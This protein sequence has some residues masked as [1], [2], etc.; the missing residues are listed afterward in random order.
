MSLSAPESRIGLPRTQT[1]WLAVIRSVEPSPAVRDLR[2]GGLRRL[3]M[4]HWHDTMVDR[5]EPNGP[6]YLTGWTISGL[7][8]IATIVAVWILGI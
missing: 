3:F 5:P 8:V 6:A 1:A 4:N 7:A 2:K